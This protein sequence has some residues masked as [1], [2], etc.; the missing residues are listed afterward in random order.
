MN[1][2]DNIYG[3]GYCEKCQR[4]IATVEMLRH[5][6]IGDAPLNLLPPLGL[7]KDEQIRD[8]FKAK[9]GLTLTTPKDKR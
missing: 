6:C 8:L 7:L 2:N 4:R 5:T 1:T 3:V 9:T